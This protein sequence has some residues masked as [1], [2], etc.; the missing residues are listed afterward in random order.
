MEASG[1]MKYLKLDKILESLTGYFDSKI[2]LVKVELREEASEFI[3]KFI[4][5]VIIALLL[6][7][8]VLFLSIS[9]AFWLGDKTGNISAG[10]A[11][12]AGFYLILSVTLLL[13]KD[14]MKLDEKIFVALKSN[15]KDHE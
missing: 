4:V 7:S 15:K 9:A 1:F 10:F 12:V 6:M 2:Q 14:K 5:F 11:I 8:F 3:S 13:L